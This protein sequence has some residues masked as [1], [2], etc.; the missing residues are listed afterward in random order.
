MKDSE[1]AGGRRAHLSPDA[2]VLL[3]LQEVEQHLQEGGVLAVGL[4]H[5]S[6]AGYL[7]AKSP[8]RHLVESQRLALQLDTAQSRAR[9]RGVRTTYLSFGQR[10][11]VLQHVHDD[12]EEL[13]HPLPHLQAAHLVGRTQEGSFRSQW[14]EPAGTVSV[15][16]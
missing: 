4:H 3:R 15:K 10:R 12:G 8:Q 16:L 6:C 1:T 2:L 14:N 11:R 5:I 13:V 7:L 9:V